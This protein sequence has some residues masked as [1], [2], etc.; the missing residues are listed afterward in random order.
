MLQ[1]GG[2]LLRCHL[3][4]FAAWA[5]SDAVRVRASSP[6]EYDRLLSKLREQTTS[7]H[8]PLAVVVTSQTQSTF[9]KVEQRGDLLALG[10]RARRLA[11]AAKKPHRLLELALAPID[12]AEPARVAPWLKLKPLECLLVPRLATRQRQTA[13]ARALETLLADSQA[14]MT[15]GTDYARSAQ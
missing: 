7:E 5:V 15:G 9:E 1:L 12:A 3:V 14:V 11:K 13:L 8:S 6:A 4:R 10:A 2:S